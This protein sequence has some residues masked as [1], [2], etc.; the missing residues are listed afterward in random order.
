MK[1]TITQSS[2]IEKFSYD[3]AG[4]VLHVYFRRGGHY[5]YNQVTPEIYQ[6]FHDAESHGKHFLQIIKPNHVFAKF[7]EPKKETNEN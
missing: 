5:G 2:L 7:D 3:T 4:Q 6:A 1:E